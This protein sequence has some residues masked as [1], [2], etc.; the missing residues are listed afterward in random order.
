MSD[1]DNTQSFP[2]GLVPNNNGGNKNNKNNKNNNNNR[3]RK[4]KSSRGKVAGIVIL[5]VVLLLIGVV[6]GGYF[7]ATHTLNKL[8]RVQLNPSDL[9]INS[10]V[11]N[12]LDKFKG[13]T[14]VVVFGVDEP[15][16]TP[17][18]SDTIMIATI[19]TTNDTLKLTSIMRDS[20]VNIPGYGMNKINAAYAFGGPQLALK[21]LNENYGMNLKYYVTENFTTLPELVNMVG[22]ITVNLSQAEIKAMVPPQSQL[23]NILHTNAPYITTPG[24][25]T[26]NGVQ[27]MAYCRIRHGTGGDYARTYRQRA[28]MQQI[29]TKIKAMPVTQVPGLV[30]KVLPTIQTNLTNSQIMNMGAEMLKMGTGTIQQARLPLNQDSHGEMISGEWYLVF[31]Q[32]QTNQQ[33]HDFIFENKPL[34]NQDLDT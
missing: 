1:M 6:G 20:Y 26:L 13:I 30:E 4:K 17:G 21:T 15:T 16:G 8:N 7:Y 27:A 5:I 14:N 32:Q 19:D 33:L 12:E 22:G 9:G 28:V 34:P 25:H 2:D 31:N 18:R 11:E 23:N 3:R 10:Q 29:F 24:E